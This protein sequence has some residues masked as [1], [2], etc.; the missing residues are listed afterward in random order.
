MTAI[1]NGNAS[2]ATGTERTHERV[3][4]C[5]QSPEAQFPET[6]TRT[7]LIVDDRPSNRK[8]LRA[9]LEADALGV[10]EAG[11]GVAALEVLER[12][13]VDLIIS[14]ALMPRMDGYTLCI[15][16]RKRDRLHKIP[17]ILL[18]STFNS[19]GDRRLAV[20]VGVDR[21]ISRPSPAKDILAAVHELWS[22]TDRSAV[23]RVTAQPELA[24]MQEYS[25]QVVG[26]LLERNAE[27]TRLSEDLG[28]AHEKVRHLLAYSPAVIY[29]MKLDGENV[30]P[31]L[32]SDNITEILGFSVQEA[33]DY[34]WWVGQIHPE[35]RERAIDSIN[36][37]LALFVT[38][39][40]YRIRHRDGSYRWGEDNRRLIRGPTEAQKEMIGVWTDITERKKLEAELRVYTEALRAS[41]KELEQFAQFASH[42]LQEPLRKLISFSAL[43]VEDL[44]GELP[45][46][47][48]KDINFITDAATRMQGLVRGLLDLSRTGRREMKVH[49]V[50]LAQCVADAVDT[51]AMRIEETHASITVDTLP[52]VQGDRLLL[53]QLF[54]NLIGNALKFIA[55]GV[56][57]EVCVTCRTV[58]SETFFGVQDH[59]IGIKPEYAELVFQPFRRLHGRSEYEGAG[60]GLAICSKAVERHGGRIWVESEHGQGAHFRFTLQPVRPRK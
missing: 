57:P 11:D 2:T 21:Y 23:A 48:R 18:T 56:R 34:E 9:I 53:T 8:L 46:A 54:Q 15:Q 44:P 27:L 37:T 38:R 7:V 12:G 42:D 51:L 40:E 3:A 32:V 52:N 4:G 35:D 19:P 33:L 55:T 24:L 5:A 13:P 20:D 1:G 31:Y 16:V 39:T 36:Q 59:G 49:E 17:F 10:M 41:N 60:I 25:Q 58:G 43:L 28:V 6:A 50:S 14:D 22:T 26:K 47:A 45:E 29:G 30:I